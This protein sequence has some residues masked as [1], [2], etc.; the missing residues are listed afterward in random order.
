MMNEPQIVQDKVSV[1]IK[2]PTPCP[3]DYDVLMAYDAYE[4]NVGLDFGSYGA[5]GQHFFLSPKEARA[6]KTEQKENIV[7]WDSLPK[8]T[9]KAIVSYLNEE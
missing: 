2:H 3:L 8:A 7:Q 4:E 6:Y 5:R 1:I 9:Q